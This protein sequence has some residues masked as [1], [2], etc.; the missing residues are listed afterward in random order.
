MVTDISRCLLSADF[1]II[2]KK[3]LSCPGPGP[4]SSIRHNCKQFET[5]SKFWARSESRLFANVFSG[6]TTSSD[7]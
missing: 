1:Y 2:L 6:V 4:S 7:S 3:Y 5:L